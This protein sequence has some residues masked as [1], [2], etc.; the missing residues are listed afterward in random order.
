M[1]SL[2]V[3]Q[4]SKYLPILLIIIVALSL[5]VAYFS[6]YQKVETYPFKQFSDSY[7]YNSWALDIESGNLLGERAFLKW[8]FYAYFLAL[9]FKFFSQDL[10][11]IYH[12]QFILGITHCLLI[13]IIA[14][15]LF[16]NFVGIAA[17]LLCSFYGLF[18]F[19]EG[20]LLYSSLSLVLNAVFLLYLLYL[21]EDKPAFHFLCLGLCLGLGAITQ[22]NAL[23]FGVPAAI[24]LIL[25]RKSKTK[26]IISL[27]LF[28][29]GV[30]LIVLSATLA[31]YLAE[32]DFVLIAGN[33]GLN[34]YLGNNNQASGIFAVTPNLGLNQGT[35]F[36]DA[37]IVAQGETQ[38]AMKTS[39]VSHFWFM[40]AVDFITSEPIEFFKC[41]FRKILYVLS[42][43]EFVHDAQYYSISDHIRVFKITFN[44]LKLI[45]PFSAIGILYALKRFRRNIFLLLGLGAFSFSICLFFVSSRYKLTVIPYWI[46]FA[47]YGLWLLFVSI[48]RKNKLIV[49]SIAGL[50]LLYFFCYFC[51]DK[52]NMKNSDFY[53]DSVFNKA[54]TSES[55]G[56][57]KE[58]IFYLEKANE[59]RKDNP[60]I[61]FTFG[62]V[63]YKMKDYTSAIAMYHE[64]IAYNHYYVDAYH[65]LGVIY[66]EQGRLA[67]AEKTLKKALSFYPESVA[68]QVEL[69]SVYKD[70]GRLDEA[71]EVF[72]KI[73]KS[74]S[75]W[76]DED[77]RSIKKEIERLQIKLEKVYMISDKISC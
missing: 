14:K 70:S 15:K 20:L 10:A 59:L 60:H 21:R 11:V 1:R 5:R 41:F 30:S 12:I 55:N 67:L 19:H 68:T 69:A 17:G 42:P 40:K 3:F 36:R 73:L 45:F 49:P 46:I 23:V 63:Y 57:Y 37:F 28:M 44:D 76:Q 27:G 29:T 58:A 38:N 77:I 9:L 18:I 31:N 75:S 71:L 35:M 53:F 26:K 56:N 51:I 66:H 24:I 54:I 33:L 52:I 64:T 50:L 32:K 7:W 61:L 25:I 72:R 4:R 74:L 39:Q 34:F 13:Y 62:S 22:G 65:N 47:A 16:N 43:L 6:D 8:P 2:N 48:Q